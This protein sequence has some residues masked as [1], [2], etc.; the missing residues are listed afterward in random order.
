MDGVYNTG[1]VLWSY[2]DATVKAQ[3]ERCVEDAKECD[4]HPCRTGDHGGFG[5]RKDGSQLPYR[6]SAGPL[7][8]GSSDYGGNHDHIH[9][10]FIVH[11]CNTVFSVNKQ[12][13]RTVVT[14]VPFQTSSIFGNVITDQ[15]G[16]TSNVVSKQRYR[17]PSVWR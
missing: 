7:G 2:N 4:D 17:V 5:S 12:S 13:I 8:R 6:I 11:I 1:V 9:S 15:V 16:N 10:E 14:R 3:F